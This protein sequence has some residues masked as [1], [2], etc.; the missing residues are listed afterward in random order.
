MG[1]VPRVKMYTTRLCGY[2][3]AAKRLL[4]KRGIAF[5]EIGVDGRDDVRAWLAATTG[6]T[7]VPQ[8][9][10]DDEPIGGYTELAALDREGKLQG[11]EEGV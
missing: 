6:Q 2:C 9:F 1:R 11:L 8:I 4:G 10:I 7:T 3:M 5:E